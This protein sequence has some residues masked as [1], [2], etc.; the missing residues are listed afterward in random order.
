M[1]YRIGIYDNDVGYARNLMEYINT[2]M[3]DC[4]EAVAFS[5]CNSLD[6][7]LVDN[8][9]DVLL[10]IRDIGRNKNIRRMMILT[11]RDKR[12]CQ[13][14]YKFI[15]KYQGAKRLCNDILSDVRDINIE[16]E[17]AYFVCVTSPL[18]RSGKT[19]YAKTMT[20]EIE[21]SLYI[22]L[23]NFPAIDL[24]T[25]NI[26]Y[27][28]ALSERFMYYLATE[29]E[30]IIELLENAQK[31][32][33]CSYL[34]LYIPYLDFESLS[35]KNFKWLKECI[36]KNCSYKKV[37]VD[38]GIVVGTSILN[39][40]DECYITTLEDEIS[41]TKLEF[42]K[43]MYLKG[44]VALQEKIKYKNVAD[45]TTGQAYMTSR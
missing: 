2:N 34:I 27:V 25:H 5:K 29:N 17:N 41:Q 30:Q 40:F 20:K 1:K 33:D 31:D 36:A 42:F 22:G 44:D 15:Y 16:D 39:A 4:L 21:N 28:K 12:G 18:G 11:E 26:E 7:Y 3:S 9:L 37:V 13:S 45:V 14:D 24:D 19:I 38:M 32:G 23:E 35:E 8:Q 43:K 6:N 10:S